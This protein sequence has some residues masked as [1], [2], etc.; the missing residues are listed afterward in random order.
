MNT[1]IN[2]IEQLIFKLDS[3]I[4]CVYNN[5]SNKN[6]GDD[7]KIILE[8]SL[9]LF[10]QHLLL[11]NNS[12]SNDGQ[13]NSHRN[14]KDKKTFNPND[15]DAMNDDDDE[16]GQDIDDDEKEK[17]NILLDSICKD[18]YEQY[19]KRLD[20]F[21]NLASKYSTNQSF[22]LSIEFIKLKYCI[23]IKE[24]LIKV[25]DQ[26][27]AIPQPPSSTSTTTTT[28]NKGEQDEVAPTSIIS[29][30][31]QKVIKSS[32]DLII[33]WGITPCYVRGIGIPLGK[34]VPSDSNSIIFNT[35]FESTL[36]LQ[37]LSQN[38][39][40]EPFLCFQLSYFVELIDQLRDGSID[41]NII[42][43]SRY[44]SDL[45]ASYL[46][47]I[48]LRSSPF[49]ITTKQKYAGKIDLLLYNV[50]PELVFEAL[51]MLLSPNTVQPP[52]WMT[53]CLTMMLS[54]CLLRPH[55]LRILLE[56]IL[57]SSAGKSMTKPLQSI[58]S[59]VSTLL[60]NTKPSPETFYE[61]ISPQLLDIIHRRYNAD[62][63]RIVE[64]VMMII[65]CLF[66]QNP[67][68]VLKHFINSIIDPLI[69]CS[70]ELH[71]SNNGGDDDNKI[72]V[73]EV[74]LFH[75]IEDLHKVLSKLG[76]NQMLLDYI[77]KIIPTLFQLYCFVSKSISTLKVSCKEIL[78]TFFKFSSST[79]SITELKNLI[80]PITLKNQHSVHN[81]QQIDKEKQQDKQSNHHSLLDLED[82]IQNEDDDNNNNT[83]DTHLSFSMGE[84]GGVVAKYISYQDRDYQWE[85]ECL[86]GILEIMKNDELAGNL[87]VDLLSEFSVLQDQDQDKLDQKHRHQYFVL[88]Q[89][90]I[91]M[92][93]RL[94]AAIL[95]NVL[96]VCTFV[97][98]MLTRSIS[99]LNSD[100]ETEEDIESLTLSLGILT[101]LLTGE[102]KVRK[103]EEIVIF[104]LLSLTE[105]LC[106][107]PNEMI[108]TM[109]SQIKTIITAKKPIWMD[110]DNTGATE[111]TSD[112]QSKL[113]EIL[114]DLS[115]P[116]LPVRAHG[117]I[118]LRR[119]VL[120]KSSLIDKNLDNVLNI[121]KTQLGDDDTFIYGCSIAG[122]AALGDIYPTRIIPLLVE[123]FINKSIPE[124]KRMKIGESLI[125][126]SQRCGESLPKYAATMV[127]A[128]LAACQPDQPVGVQS[129]SLSNLSTLC[130][131]LHYSID[132]YLVDILSLINDIL[133]TSKDSEIR[134]GAI[135]IFQMLLKGLGKDSFNLIPDQLKQIYNTLK[136]IEFYDTDDI[137]KYHAR[138]ALYELDS[139]TKSFI[140]PGNSNTDDSNQPFGIRKLN[141]S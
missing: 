91:I 88:I 42:I 128:F 59:L 102:I 60:A 104:D 99:K 4:S 111:D 126:I 96:Q 131:L 38:N 70:T 127:N 6:N 68:F 98:V 135:F 107:H 65:E 87:F 113:K 26:L 76:F 40:N 120:S 130:E 64:A 35:L 67:D 31:N 7:S 94:G 18:I 30:N 41:L 9:S 85:A 50:Y 37:P 15:L 116:L 63:S 114:A 11:P 3:L 89:F 73:K 45:F 14:V 39:V 20:L 56:T 140:F 57:T 22:T 23:F 36:Y 117:L 43:V 122:L 44:L 54:K 69:K 48:N 124:F 115:H 136:N 103:E 46:Q 125:Q 121:F 52:V 93:D 33:C 134:R 105:Q 27:N 66:Q 80:L 34:R 62:K 81:S 92:S 86:I 119:M 109:A 1:S 129:S 61:K 83:N 97:K 82:V 32:L 90:I 47:L 12:S 55:A 13:D 16:E 28:T 123:Q 108:A 118:E 133:S 74:E 78:C 138:S 137:C 53:K 10:I 84:S 95:K 75:C 112:S 101:T 2:I 58:V 8:K 100:Q 110:H 19:K 132:P 24:I 17:E 25:Q 71:N 141:I 49:D 29:I 77:S 72:V 5:N 51:T 106:Y 21:I 139:I 79:T